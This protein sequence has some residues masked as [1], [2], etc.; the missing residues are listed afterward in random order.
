MPTSTPGIASLPPVGE[1]VV[2]PPAPPSGTQAI[3]PDNLDSVRLLGVLP[4]GISGLWPLPDPGL[5]GNN[6][7]AIYSD[8]RY[9]IG[10]VMAIQFWDLMR[11][12]QDSVLDFQ[13]ADR[14]IVARSED[15]TLLAYTYGYDGKIHLYDVEQHV[16]R[17]VLSPA[18]DDTFVLL[19]HMAISPDKTALAISGDDV[20][21]QVWDLTTYQQRLILPTS[22]NAVVFTP[23]SS[24]IVISAQRALRFFNAETGALDYSLANVGLLGRF[25]PDG[26]LMA[27]SVV[28][29]FYNSD[30]ELQIRDVK[31]RAI[32]ARIPCQDRINLA[33]LAFSPDGQ[34]L[35]VSN[36]YGML[37]LL[38]VQTGDALASFKI[39]TYAPG[40][41]FSPDGKLLVINNPFQIIDLETGKIHAVEGNYIGQSPMFSA[42]GATLLLGDTTST[43]VFGI[44][45]GA[46]PEW[47]LIT[48]HIIPSGVN[49]RS[50]PEQSAAVIGTASGDVRISGR[51]SG[52]VYLPDLGGWVWSD[53]DYLDLGDH[54]LAELPVIAFE[55]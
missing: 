51:N 23:D 15:G 47:Q 13:R 1:P 12:A 18:P 5:Q 50:A 28:P 53:D 17:A 9:N 30:C 3:S 6:Y 41:A 27:T 52:G 16:E 35:A 38:D 24:Q 29:D 22:G 25:S 33:P 2:K 7:M 42:D 10:R 45:N 8:Y 37:Q 21:T 48:G 31:T 54:T 40:V 19:A 4:V 49:V 36:G 11:L 32:R 26:S 55:S 39:T 46:R 34:M 20:A 44:P 14:L 43:M